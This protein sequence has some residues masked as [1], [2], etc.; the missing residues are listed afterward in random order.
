MAVSYIFTPSTIIASAEVNQNFDDVDYSE[1]ANNKAVQWYN[2]A[3]GLSAYIKQD[4]SDDLLINNPDGDLIVTADTINLTNAPVVASP[5][6]LISAPMLVDATTNT[7]LYGAT[8]QSGTPDGDGFRIRYEAAYGGG[9]ADYLIIEKTDGN[10]T[11][12]DGGIIFVLTGN[13]GVVEE[14]LEIGGDGVVKIHDAN[15]FEMYDSTD[16]NK[17]YIQNVGSNVEIGHSSGNLHI[18]NSGHVV[19]LRIYSTAGGSEYGDIY[20]DGTFH[21]NTGAGDIYFDPAGGDVMFR[22]GTDVRVYNA[23]NTQY[24]LNAMG[25]NWDFSTTSGEITMNPAGSFR[26]SAG[27]DIVLTPTGSVYITGG[28]KLYLRN[29]ADS[30]Q[31]EI[32]TDSSNDLIIDLASSTDQVHLVGGSAFKIYDSTNTYTGTLNMSTSSFMISSGSGGIFLSSSTGS[33]EITND[34][35]PKLRVWQGSSFTAGV[36]I[37]HQGLGQYGVLMTSADILRIS[38]TEALGVE[39]GIDMETGSDAKWLRVPNVSS[40]ASSLSNG[41]IWYDTSA[42]KFKVREGGS[43]KTITTS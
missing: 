8:N 34:T 41:M 28:K 36:D 31:S 26:I 22:S 2:S 17:F 1:I 16:T 3:S 25:T 18:Y 15:N 40:A 27:S 37:Y 33:V 42:G 6:N 12:P 19:H 38:T 14:S 43:T 20:H 32:Y 10:Q 7:I 4:S 29:P 21:I 13:D 30:A 11:S 9:T 23:A 35:H 24:G 39:T 5:L